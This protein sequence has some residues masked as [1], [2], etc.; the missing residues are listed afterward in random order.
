M[1]KDQKNIVTFV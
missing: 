1:T